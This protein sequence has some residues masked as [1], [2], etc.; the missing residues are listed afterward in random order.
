MA[1]AQEW[2]D[3]LQEAIRLFREDR[4]FASGLVVKLT[5]ADGDSFYV[6]K[7]EAGPGEH[8]VTLSPYPPR[9][10]IAEEMVNVEEELLPET[11]T[12]CVVRPE[13]IEKIEVLVDAPTSHEVG[14]RLPDDA[15]S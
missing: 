12:I 6:M 3:V 10:S 1:P 4:R 13:F 8:F 11:P 9:R 5:L 7:A 2:L 15:G 14:F